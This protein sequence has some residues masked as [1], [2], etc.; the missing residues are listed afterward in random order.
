M[1]A[2]MTN[3][4]K[5]P[6]C[7]GNLF[8]SKDDVLEM[9]LRIEGAVQCAVALD[10]LKAERLRVA[11]PEGQLIPDDP[12]GSALTICLKDLRKHAESLRA[13]CE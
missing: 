10:A 13:L 2:M 9:F 12:L 4:S 8:V 6:D 3:V 7:S 5:F 1:G 11:T